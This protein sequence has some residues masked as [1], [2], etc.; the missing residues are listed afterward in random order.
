M[1]VATIKAITKRIRLRYGSTEAVAAAAGISPGVWSGYENADHPQTTIPLGR[2]L[3]MSLTA[4]ERRA[5]ASLFAVNEAEE[6]AD[7]MSE[8]MEATEAVCRVQ[9]MVRLAAKDGVI[10]EA[11]ARP[12]RAA[13]LEARAQLDDV[14]QGV[15]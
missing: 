8:T 7:L 10:T 9:S 3:D 12:I 13:A 6:A 5:F 1:S 11:E 14:I 4:A 2:L 15:G